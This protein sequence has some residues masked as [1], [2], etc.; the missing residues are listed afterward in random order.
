MSARSGVRQRSG[1]CPPEPEAPHRRQTGEEVTARNWAEGP[2]LA[3]GDSGH[4]KV[5]AGFTKE[6]RLGWVLKT[7]H[8]FAK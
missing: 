8:E 6:K 5:I 2:N 3:S 7:E 4:Q 1:P